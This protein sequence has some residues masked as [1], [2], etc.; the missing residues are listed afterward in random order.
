MS[1]PY[2]TVAFCLPVCLDPPPQTVNTGSV[3]ARGTH[4]CH[5]GLHPAHG[6]SQAA[7]SRTE[8]LSISTPYQGAD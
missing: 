1:H 8:S 5:L 2:H 4:H 7:E 3:G 6:G